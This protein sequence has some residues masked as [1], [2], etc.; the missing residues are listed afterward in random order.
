MFFRGSQ[1]IESCPE[2]LFPNF[3]P[4]KFFPFFFFVFLRLVPFVLCFGKEGCFPLDTLKG[5]KFLIPSDV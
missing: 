3:F 5:R 4:A 1:C 2:I